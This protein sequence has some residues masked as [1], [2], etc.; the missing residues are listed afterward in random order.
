MSDTPHVFF[1][2][3]FNLAETWTETVKVFCTPQAGNESSETESSETESSEPEAVEPATSEPE[4]SEPEAVEPESSEPEAVANSDGNNPDDDTVD[5][6]AFAAIAGTQVQAASG[7]APNTHRI[8]TMR[9]FSSLLEAAGIGLRYDTVLRES[10]IA[11]HRPEPATICAALNIEGRPLTGDTDAIIQ[12][13]DGEISGNN[14]ATGDGLET[15]EQIANYLKT[16]LKIWNRYYSRGAGIACSESDFL[17]LLERTLSRTKFSPILEL[18]EAGTWD[19][20]DR[21]PEVIAILGLAQNCGH[22]A[23]VTK[24]L[25]QCIAALYNDG[26]FGLEGAL[27]LQGPQGLGKTSFFRKLA[28]RREWFLE[29][30]S[31]PKPDDKDSISKA[32]KGWIGEL[33]EIESTF[34]RAELGA[35]KAFLTAA[36][37]TYRPPFGRSEVT[38]PRRTVFGG[39]CNQGEFLRDTTGNR[40]FW[41]VP[42]TKIDLKRLEQLDVLQLWR[43][44][45]AVVN[46]LSMD[47]KAECFRLENETKAFLEKSNKDFE[48]LLPGEA[49]MTED[50]LPAC[51]I[52]KYKALYP[53][54]RVEALTASGIKRTM[55]EHD[56]EVKELHIGRVLAKLGYKRGNIRILSPRTGEWIRTTGYNLL[57]WSAIRAMEKQKKEAERAAF[58]QRNEAAKLNEDKRNSLDI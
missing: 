56:F 46:P 29:S 31:L 10:R 3:N 40:R 20:E 23:L 44:I 50:I 37:D 4:S 47:D 32:T 21:I 24:W 28:I 22:A 34:S 45:Y 26:S 2:N 42:V 17:S 55:F 52:E 54:V 53:T 14:W 7:G 8:M 58:T 25:Y 48:A 12:E 57:T 5:W 39:G 1:E 19:G 35:L 41:V 18:L 27:V 30:L 9:M 13:L 16:I 15:L 11:Y 6:G 33:G 38:Y 51:E 36:R 43:Q 49:V